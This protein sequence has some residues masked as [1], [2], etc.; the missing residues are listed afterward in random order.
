MRPRS[1]PAP[2]ASAAGSQLF[3]R[4]RDS[5]SSKAHRNREDSMWRS[6]ALA[7]GVASLLLAGAPLACK[8]KGAA[9]GAEAEKQVSGKK[10]L[11]WYDPMKPE[12]HFDHP[13]KSPF[14]DMQ[15][16]P[17]YAEEAP[18]PAAGQKKVLYWYDPMKPEVH[19]DHPGK[20]PFMDMQLEPKYAEEPPAAGASAPAGLSVVRIPLERRQEIGVTTAKVQKRTIGESIETNGVV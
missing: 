19:F 18:A 2:P 20:S 7:I 14:M 6:R 4:R 9:K 5:R 17:K 3:K 13:G 10:V 8:K 11:Y 15:L 16:E 12:V 1:P